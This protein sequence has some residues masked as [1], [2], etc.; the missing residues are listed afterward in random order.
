MENATIIWNWI[1]GP[2]GSAVGT[3]VG[4]IT[5][6]I[7]LPSVFRQTRMAR[8]AA[9]GAKIAADSAKTAADAAAKAVSALSSK[10]NL[11]NASYASGQLATLHF[12]VQHKHFGE[13]HT[14][15]VTVKRTILQ[16]HHSKAKV[17]EAAHVAMS[18]I[19]KQLSLANQQ[20]SSYRPSRLNKAI[21]GLL[22]QLNELEK[23]SMNS[24]AEA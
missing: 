10:I 1:T 14:Y 22:E 2:N 6:L 13:A 9:A 12:M 19:E 5:A 15:Y 8:N 24:R 18:A 21:L 16:A 3:W 20:D 23:Q 7:G 11:S 17:P 4:A